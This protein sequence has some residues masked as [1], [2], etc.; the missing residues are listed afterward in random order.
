MGFR[1]R[2]VWMSA[3]IVKCAYCRAER[4]LEETF[5]NGPE[6]TICFQCIVDV[7]QFLT[8]V[9]GNPPPPSPLQTT[10][11]DSNSQV[12]R[13]LIEDE[14]VRRRWIEECAK[15]RDSDD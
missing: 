10:P 9:I 6:R 13:E 15:I 4:A 1:V 8:V 3:E 11:L 14:D 7:H 5:S 2:E 12:V